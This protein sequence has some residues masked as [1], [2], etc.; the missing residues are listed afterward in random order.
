MPAS[1]WWPSSRSQVC[2]LCVSLSF[3]DWPFSLRG[4]AAVNNHSYMQ[5]I[6]EFLSSVVIHS[7][8]VAILGRSRGQLPP[9][10]NPHVGFPPLPQVWRVTKKS[11]HD[12][13]YWPIACIDRHQVCCHQMCSSKLK[14]HQ[15][16]FRPGLRP[17]TSWESLRHFPIPL[18]GCTYLCPVWFY[19]HVCSTLFLHIT[20]KYQI[21]C[22]QMCSFKLKMHQNRTPLGELMT[23]PRPHSR[24]GRETS[25]PHSLPPWHLWCLDLNAFGALAP[26]F[27]T[28]NTNSWL[29]HRPSRLEGIAPSFAGL[30]LPLFITSA[31]MYCDHASLLVR[32]LVT[33]V[34][35]SWQLQVRFS[36]NFAQLL[37]Q[38]SLLAVERSRWK[39]KVKAVVLKSS[40]LY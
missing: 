38:I 18:I 29:C 36:R 24:V 9:P 8:P 5:H 23:L 19:I 33:L 14:M 6:M 25:P 13:A 2:I 32:S 37:Y 31:R 27:R 40:N 28:P 26:R 20:K 17:W 4:L 12:Y 1:H 30:E 34:V 22:H 15:N 39:F 11:V 21:C 3:S 16:R 7:L 35:I 10:H